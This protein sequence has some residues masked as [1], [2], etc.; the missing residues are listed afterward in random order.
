D[1]ER[2]LRGDGEE[3]TQE[4]PEGGSPP[5]KEIRMKKEP[6]GEEKPGKDSA[7]PGLEK[8]KDE[9]KDVQLERAVELLKGW[10]IFKTRFIDK[11]KAS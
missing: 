9:E 6:P 2:H 10:E 5:G 3:G 1:I 4:T 11:A 7:T 8:K